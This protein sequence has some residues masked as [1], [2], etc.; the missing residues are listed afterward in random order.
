MNEIEIKK[1]QIYEYKGLKIG[2]WKTANKKFIRR[3]WAIIYFGDRKYLS[4]RGK[5]IQKNFLPGL[6]VLALFL[7]KIAEIKILLVNFAIWRTA[8]LILP[9]RWQQL[10]KQN[11]LGEITWI[12]L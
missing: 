3:S 6:N 2:I 4:E 5:K 8:F 11:P 9:D 12:Q 10:I 1:Y 7:Q